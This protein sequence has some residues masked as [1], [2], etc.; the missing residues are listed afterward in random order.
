M[1]IDIYT[2][3]TGNIVLDNAHKKV[4]S[5]IDSY[6]VGVV[7]RNAMHTFIIHFS[8]ELY[9]FLRSFITERITGESLNFKRSGLWPW[10]RL[11]RF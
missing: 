5:R 8:L 7:D 10:G 9:C 6:F 3:I 2:Y 4:A 1:Y 11:S